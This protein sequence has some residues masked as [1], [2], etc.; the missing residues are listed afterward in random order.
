MT[1][2]LSLGVDALFTWEDPYYSGFCFAIW[3]YL[4]LYFDWSRGLVVPVWMLILLLATTYW[5]RLNGKYQDEWLEHVGT[6]NLE[7]AWITL[8]LSHFS[9]VP[10]SSG[11]PV[12]QAVAQWCHDPRMLVEEAFVSVYW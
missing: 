3:I 9:L 12:M 5:R 4:S 10:P 7:T 11:S 8:N 1:D 2:R 6:I